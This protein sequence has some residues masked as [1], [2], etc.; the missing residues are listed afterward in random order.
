MSRLLVITGPPGAGKSTAAAIIA[1]RFNKSAVVSSDSFYGFLA[2]G[3]IDPWLPA[4]QEQNE[5][6]H[7]VQHRRDVY[8]PR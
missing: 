4:A 1:E 6:I 5:L 7:R 2:N 8:R 3:G